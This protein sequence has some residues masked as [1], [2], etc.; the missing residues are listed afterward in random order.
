MNILLIN[1]SPRIN[2]NT[3]KILEIFETIL[4]STNKEENHYEYVSLSNQKIGICKG[5]RACFQTSEEKC[6]YQDDLLVIKE[7]LEQS[8]VIIIGSPVYVEDISGLLK[9]WIDR[10]AFN[11]HRP[12][13]CGK[14]VYIFTTSGS[15]ASK[16]AI[17]TLKHTFLAWGATMIAQDNFSMGT[18]MSLEDANTKF[19]NLIYDRTKTLM[20]CKAKKRI[21]LFSL[22]GFS[23]Q[24]SYWK[25]KS[26]KENLVDVTYWSHNGWLD[27]ECFYYQPVKVSI[28]KKAIVLII[29]K[30]VGFILY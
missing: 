30:I 23:V 4:N 8:D 24:K 11:T 3:M 2:G 1:G 10:M 22:I 6:P 5:C 25:M 13:L 14:P 16:H 26:S 28:G 19:S 18:K 20:L 29:S 27:N 21:P 9:N 15:G 7:K 17:K 12:F